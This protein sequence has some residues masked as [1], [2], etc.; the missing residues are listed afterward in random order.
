M[1]TLK[2]SQIMD[3]VTKKGVASVYI[4]VHA[5]VLATAEAAL[6]VGKIS[7]DVV[8]SAHGV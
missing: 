3:A 2:V 6:P 8:W 4:Q 7:A 1:S 5:T